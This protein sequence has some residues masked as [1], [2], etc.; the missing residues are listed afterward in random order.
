MSQSCE[1]SIANGLTNGNTDPTNTD[2]TNKAV[3]VF[4]VD[5]K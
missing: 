2:P 1:K 4:K 3:N 5:N